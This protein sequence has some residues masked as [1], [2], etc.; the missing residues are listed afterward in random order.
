MSSL[1]SVPFSPW[2][3]LSAKD[4]V[5]TRHTRSKST[6]VGYGLR[7]LA[8]RSRY[9]ANEGWRFTVKLDDGRS[10]EFNAGCMLWSK[11]PDRL[12]LL[13]TRMRERSKRKNS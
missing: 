6:V 13:L 1:L 11:T 2:Y 8:F 4:A 9:V 3:E 7:L 10:F 5:F 12:L